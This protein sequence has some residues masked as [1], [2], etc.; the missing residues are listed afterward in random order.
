MRNVLRTGSL[1]VV[2]AILAACN[3]S[4]PSGAE[5]PAASATTP[6]ASASAGPGASAASTMPSL[7]RGDRAP[8]F[9]LVGSDG[10]THSLADHAGKQ[11]VVLAWFPKAFT[12][13]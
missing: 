1:A 3:K 13:G 2:L 12:S 6:A 10:K 8:D 11:V 9:H 5:Q 7:A 4:A